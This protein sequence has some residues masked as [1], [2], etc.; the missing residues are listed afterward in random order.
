[1][2]LGLRPVL[3]FSPVV[4]TFPRGA[5]PAATSVY[6]G[7]MAGPHDTRLLQTE[8][9][10]WRDFVSYF[11]PFHWW[12][13]ARRRQVARGEDGEQRTGGTKAAS[14]LDVPRQYEEA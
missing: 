11:A 3:P 14:L 7:V 4:I 6:A 13:R 2:I 10:I 8:H 5:V 12:D 1:M 9:S